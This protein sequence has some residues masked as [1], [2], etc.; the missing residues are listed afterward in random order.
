MLLQCVQKL[1]VLGLLRHLHDVLLA[2]ARM[3]HIRR[4][5]V[6]Q[7]VRVA[8]A[9]DHIDRRGLLDLRIFQAFHHG[10][11]TLRE[12]PPVAHI[13]GVLPPGAVIF[14][15]ALVN[16]G[17]P[18]G[19]PV[20]YQRQPGGF[21]AVRSD[22]SSCLEMVPRLFILAPAV[23][24]IGHGPHQLL[25]LFPDTTEQVDDLAVQVVDGLDT[26]RRLFEEYGPAPEERFQIA[27][28]RRHE[29]YNPFRQPPFA[30]RI[31][32]HGLHL[33]CRLECLRVPVDGLSAPAAE[34][35]AVPVLVVEIF[36]A[37]AGRAGQDAFIPVRV[38]RLRHPPEQS[39]PAHPASLVHDLKA[40][41]CLPVLRVQNLS[42]S[43]ISHGVP[44]HSTSSAGRGAG[45]APRSRSARCFRCA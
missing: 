12:L 30:P 37:P 18:V 38:R 19:L 35:A 29:G 42:S 34:T 21:D 3:Q 8:E 16:N 15:T 6:D 10:G 14:P 32:Q 5:R 33:A 20:A 2:L 13:V 9:P 40:L 27:L 24:R 17:A 22:L 43:F 31:F 36:A 11:D 39:R 26:A 4:V 45:I 25:R 44:P 7:H 23:R 41:V 28:V 1:D